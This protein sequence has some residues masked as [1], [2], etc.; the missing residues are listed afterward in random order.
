VEGSV[1][2]GRKKTETQCCARGLEG[3][4]KRGQVG[5]GNEEAPP[6]RIRGR[7]KNTKR[8]N[9]GGREVGRNR[10]CPGPYRGIF[11][12]RRLLINCATGGVGGGGV[13]GNKEEKPT[14]PPRA[15]E[16]S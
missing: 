10:K 6:T 2:G 9:A 3:N 14:P 11:N 13:L 15:A 7:T 16:S 5:W 4:R 1:S 12:E 8:R